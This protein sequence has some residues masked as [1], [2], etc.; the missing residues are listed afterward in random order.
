M[1]S[2]IEPANDTFSAV[3]KVLEYLQGREDALVF[4]KLFFEVCHELDDIIDVPERRED[5][6]FIIEFT[7]KLQDC[8]SCAFY[9]NH[10]RELYPLVKVAL[11]AYADSVKWER[12]EDKA[13]FTIGDVLRCNGVEVEAQVVRIVVSEQTGNLEAGYIAMRDVSHR[14]RQQAWHNHHDEKGNPI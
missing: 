6:E 13:C 11:N 5:P 10:V 4:I 8:F 7:S 9:V 12:S 14:L 3:A 1:P 2:N